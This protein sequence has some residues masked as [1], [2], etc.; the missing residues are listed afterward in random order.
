MRLF[1]LISF[2]G[3]LGV[4][5]TPCSG[6]PSNAA[7]QGISLVTGEALFTFQY[8]TP[9]ASPRNWIGLYHASGGGPDNQQHNENSLYWSYAPLDNGK[10]KVSASGLE[11][12]DYKAYFLADD[13]YKWLADPIKVTLSNVGGSLSLQSA[14]S[15]SVFKFSAQK[16]DS[17][18][19]VGIWYANGGAPVNGEKVTSPTVWAYTPNTGSGTV[20]VDTS[21][22]PPGQYVAYLLYADGY[23]WL[24]N[25]IDFFI[26]SS[27]SVSFL[28][29]SFTTHRAKQG[30]PFATDITGLL[31]SAKD[32]NTQF[33]KVDANDGDWIDVS[34]LGGI[35]GTPPAGAD[36]TSTVTVEATG[37]DGSKA[38]LKVSIPIQKTMDQLVVESFNLWFGGA[39]V[40]NYHQKQ[41]KHILKSGADLVGLQESTPTHGHRLAQALG[42]YAWQGHDAS[43]ISRY[44]IVKTYAAT[45]VSVA[46]QIS[47]HYDDVKLVMWNA[48]L[49][50]DPYGP[51]DFCY[52][53]MT[54]DQVMQREAD[55]GRT[56]QIK[57]ITAAMADV[58]KNADD[59]PVLLTGDFNSASHLDWTDANKH[60]GV[61]YV[62]WPSTKYPVDAG[63]IDSYR[64]IHPDPA[65]DAGITWSPIYLT[66]G[67]YG[68]KPEPLDRIDFV[69][70]K[71]NRLQPVS[72]EAVLEGTP[73]PEPNH[74]D[75][76]WPSDHKAVRTVFKI[77]V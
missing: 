3:A 65:K 16:T 9:Q 26:P 38:T 52:S 74:K 44:P 14:G 28:V 48:H 40:N 63:M 6:A 22:L 2:I 72:S 15:S 34:P 30:T 66:N 8:S 56:P 57:E 7:A 24:A 11:P 67:D 21:G 17:K 77:S 58:I 41:I 61:G 32:A 42:W 47:L 62:P 37:S 39:Q 19:W 1:S 46:V 27:G 43:I 36:R 35:A 20:S 25:P 49:G 68:N 13:G 12:G 75:N 45:G 53:H 69:F 73:K 70:Y 76:E 4:W 55:S 71:G 23:S 29:D 64:A 50:Y 59:M 60:C 31:G 18:N 51:Y 54:L 5:C 33:K 10:V